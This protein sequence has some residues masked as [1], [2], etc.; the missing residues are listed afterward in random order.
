MIYIFVFFW[1]LYLTVRIITNVFNLRNLQRIRK[2]STKGIRSLDKIQLTVQ[3][4]IYLL[5]GRV[6]R[7]F[8]YTHPSIR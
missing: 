5:M 3:F 1:F 7:S 4:K 6:L 2:K 8:K